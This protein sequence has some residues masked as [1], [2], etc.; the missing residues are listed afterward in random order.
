MLNFI[1]FTL[2]GLVIFL[3]IFLGG[4]KYRNT[5]LYALAIGGVVNAN[6]FH[7]GLY[8]IDCFGLPFGIDSIL[9]TLFVFC[10]AYTL[11][12][13]DRKS[14]YL[15]AFSGII[16]IIFSAL[17]QLFADI[18]SNGASIEALNTFL[19]FIISA[20]ASVVAIVVIIE[21]LNRLKIKINSYFLIIIGVLIATI[22][23]SGIYFPLSCLING[24]PANIF[25][26][27]LTSFLGK[28]L[29]LGFSLLTFLLLNILDKHH[30]P[31]HSHSS[32]K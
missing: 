16:A 17:M 31:T 8:P 25:T 6:F 26:L 30:F 29:T 4:K 24:T 11:I 23:N 28:L 3:S 22:I 2:S 14:A 7:S 32:Q 12:K 20:F 27:L 21:V 9:Y 10:V 18:L 19:G 13:E 15:I 5:A 1:L